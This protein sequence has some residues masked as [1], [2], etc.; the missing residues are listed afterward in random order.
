LDST[1]R[2]LE[3]KRWWLGAEDPFQ[4]LA[5]CINLAETLRSLSPETTISY[6]PI[7]QVWLHFLLMYMHSLMYTEQA[8]NCSTFLMVVATFLFCSVI[9]I[10]VIL[11]FKKYS[12]WVL[13]RSARVE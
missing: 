1:D 10:F 12:C 13:F 9:P 3:G 4:C 6:I 11:L 7:H 8:L 2:P 5:V